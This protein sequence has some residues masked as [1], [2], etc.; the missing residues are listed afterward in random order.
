MIRAGRAGPASTAAIRAPTQTQPSHGGI[1]LYHPGTGRSARHFSAAGGNGVHWLDQ[2][3]DRSPSTSLQADVRS[4][5]GLPEHFWLYVG[6]FRLNKNLS[7]LFDAYASACT[8]GSAPP[9]V[10]AG[11]VPP[12]DTPFTGPFHAAIDQH[13]GLRQKIIFPGFVP[14]S[15]L[16][17]LYRL[18]DLLICPSSY[19]G[20]G[21]PV[22]ESAAVG[23]PVIA[24][25]ATSF[26][27]LGLPKGSLF[28][29]DDPAELSSLLVQFLPLNSTGI[30]PF[31]WREV[32]ESFIRGMDSRRPLRR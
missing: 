9:L 1:A 31:D 15:D 17:A 25:R 30:I 11:R 23:T 27:E 14:D 19:E 8:H 7:L 10:I 22:I 18:S 26:P 24:A 6:G 13:P 12:T 21:Y 32:S 2:D 28:S 29:P 20:F 3:Y 16:S 5:L 4:R